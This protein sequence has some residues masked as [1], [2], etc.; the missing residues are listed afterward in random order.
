MLNNIAYCQY[1]Y[2][3]RKALL[4][5]I[6]KNQFL[7]KEE[8]EEMLKRARLHDL[9]KMTLY[10]F[11]EK[12]K[13][14]DYHRSH[15]PHHLAECE[16]VEIG[17]Y[18]KM[19]AIFDFECAALTKW[20]KPLNAFDTMKKWYPEY[21]AELLPIL[22]KLHMDSSYIAI[23]DEA[24]A[25]ICQFDEVTEDMILKEVSMYLN[26]KENNVY[27]ILGDEL[28]TNEEYEK[29]KNYK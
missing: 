20:D 2:R 4:Y 29:V 26:E 5:Y 13:S 25:Y 17:Y 9:D 7:T 14:S 3:H 18:D 1:T 10:L 22:Q 24:K 23:D 19:E 16:D 21:E 12:E 27:D 8:K 28:C 11:W 6:Q 15:N